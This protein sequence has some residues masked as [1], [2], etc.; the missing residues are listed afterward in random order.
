MLSISFELIRRRSLTLSE[1]TPSITINGSVLLTEEAPRRFM[2]QLSSP[3]ADD[4]R[5]MLT[6]ATWPWR[7]CSGLLIAPFSLNA[8]ASTTVTAPE[9]D[10]FFA[11]P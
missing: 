3:G 6:P 10:S 7:A 1:A 8:L 2:L 11:V 5:V 4:E 9:R